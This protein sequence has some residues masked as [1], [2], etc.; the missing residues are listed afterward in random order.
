MIQQS[1]HTQFF[2]GTVR[3][4][5]RYFSALSDVSSAQMIHRFPGTY[6][7]H[8]LLIGRFQ[9]GDPHSCES[10]FL[11]SL[12]RMILLMGGH[13]PVPYVPCVQIWDG[14]AAC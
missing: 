5:A 7:D 10:T 8:S 12:Q 4:M 1:Y 3:G 6:G 9:L 2:V 14:A 13:N 11:I